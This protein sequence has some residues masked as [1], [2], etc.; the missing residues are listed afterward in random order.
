VVTEPERVAAL[1]DDLIQA[2]IRAGIGANVIW[3]WWRRGASH[4][5]IRRYI[6]GRR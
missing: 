4:A 3:S 6:G 1:F 5:D 2:G